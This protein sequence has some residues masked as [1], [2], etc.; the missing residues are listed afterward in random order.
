MQEKRYS[1][2]I[3]STYEDLKAE[4]QAVQDAVISAGDFPV[5]M[6][7]FPAADEDQFEFIKTL[8][9]S[10]DYY[11]LIVAGRYGKP[12]ADGKSYTE[13][14]F[15]YAVSKGIPILV[16]LHGDRQSLP[17]SKCESTPEGKER[18]NAFVAEVEHN[19]LRK[20][21][22]SAESLKLAVFEALVYAKATKPAVGWVRGNMVAS[23]DVL[24]ELNDLRKENAKFRDTIGNLEVELALPPI[25][26][27]NSSVLVDV[28]PVAARRGGE[29]S[30]ASGAT[31]AT[32]WIAAFP[33]FFN[34]LRF[35]TG[36]WNGEG[37][38]YV[39]E[40]DS[41]IAIGSALAGEVVYFDTSKSFRITKST[42]D[43]LMSYYIEAGLMNPAGAERPFSEG[44]QRVARRHNITHNSAFAF[45]VS[46]GVIDLTPGSTARSDLSDE[47]PF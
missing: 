22:Q 8:I 2:F 30:Q 33:L 25:P 38:Y 20:T 3:S 24:E 31:I 36:D 11:V 43:R 37:S 1:I 27:A 46:R 29:T 28:L 14:E 42:L 19:R 15:R 4:R 17:I 47:T 34:N 7:S 40:D 12:A 41:C 18:L 6:E 5:Q 9:D 45:I 39:H 35:S 10:C 13:K 21:W 32:T 26:D 23:I 44:A 16:M